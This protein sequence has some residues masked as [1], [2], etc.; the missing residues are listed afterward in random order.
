MIKFKKK[1][2]YL[3]IYY[4]LNKHTTTIQFLKYFIFMISPLAREKGIKYREKSLSLS[5]PEKDN[6][7]III[8][9]RERAQVP[10]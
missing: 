5:L 7:R 4:F 3:K 2:V 10:R 8:G 6:L 1:M 9:Q